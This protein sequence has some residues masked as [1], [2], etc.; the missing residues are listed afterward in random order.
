[1]GWALYEAPKLAAT[2]GKL[3]S[4]KK[5]VK[6]FP[7]KKGNPR[8]SGTRKSQRAPKRGEK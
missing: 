8:G 3:A 1:M 5:K 2:R 4:W 6:P 7:Q